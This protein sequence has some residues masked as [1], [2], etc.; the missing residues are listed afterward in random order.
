MLKSDVAEEE[1]ISIGDVESFLAEDDPAKLILL[2]ISQLITSKL[3]VIRNNLNSQQEG[4]RTQTKPKHKLVP[5]IPDSTD[6]EGRSDEAEREKTLEEKG[7]ERELEEE[8][9]KD[10]P[11]LTEDE[12]RNLLKEALESDDK[13]IIVAAPIRGSDL[14][15]DVTNP[16]GKIKLTINSEHPF[17]KEYVSKLESDSES[18]EIL[19]AIKLVFSAWA[20]MEDR[21][22]DEA[23]YNELLEIR[24]DWGAKAK[25]MI[26]QYIKDME[27]S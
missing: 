8:I 12:K 6:D 1:Q 23:L 22:Q 13:F 14:L 15:Y 21:T 20:L 11:G 4:T 19:D 2:N 7:K 25:F 10:N 5:G 16:A 24:K 27:P 18:K 3:R 9:E 26:K 17:Y